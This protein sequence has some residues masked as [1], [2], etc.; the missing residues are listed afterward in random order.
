MYKNGERFLDIIFKD[1]YKSE[2]V[3][4]TKEK[5]DTKEDS[6]NRYLNRLEK[7]H[8]KANIESKKNLIKHLYYDKYVIKQEDI[9]GK[10]SKEKEDIIENQ[11]K[12]LSTWI[13]YLIDDNTE[14]PMWAKYWVFQQVLKIGTYDEISGKYTKRTKYTIN[15]FVEVIPEVISKCINNIVELFKDKKMS[16]QEIRKL[17]SNISF[18]KMYIKYSKKIKKQYS[19]NEGIWIKYNQGSDEAAKKLYESLEGQN[20][21]WC[22]VASVTAINQVNSGDFYVYYTKDKN[23]NYIIPRIAIRFNGHDNIGEIRG[24]EEHQ[25]LEE[26][27][28]PILEDFLINKENLLTED[29]KKNLEKIKD[30]KYLVKIKNKTI[31]NEKLTTKEI[32]DLYTKTFGFGRK[33]DPLVGKII[34]KRDILSDYYNLKDENVFIKSDFIIK[35]LKYFSLEEKKEVLKNR[36]VLKKVLEKETSILKFIS[37]EYKNDREIMLIAINTNPYALEHAGEKIK[38]DKEVVMTAVKKDGFV[39]NYVSEYLKKDKE[40][41]REASLT[42]PYALKMYNELYNNASYNSL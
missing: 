14:Y 21:G 26:E 29:V 32:I 24:V 37:D 27:M 11:K 39:I 31:N 28:I 10:N 30:L 3:L 2:E 17:V 18:E 5:D 4:H 33:Q 13:D 6:I 23:D 35:N 12:T 1:L 42:N 20:T 22:T 36:E 41:L 15:P 25:N 7:I 34:K 8:K 38:N 40:V 9:K 19:S 16:T